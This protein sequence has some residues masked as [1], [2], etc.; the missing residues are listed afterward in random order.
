MQ[1]VQEEQGR[2]IQRLRKRQDRMEEQQALETQVWKEEMQELK[3]A[4]NGRGSFEMCLGARALDRMERR[5]SL[6]L[7]AAH[8]DAHSKTCLG[9]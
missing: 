5:L 1:A 3:L 9:D 7:L 2:E 6:K 8:K 4:G